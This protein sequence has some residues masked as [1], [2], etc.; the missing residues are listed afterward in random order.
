MQEG[1]ESLFSKDVLTF[2][3]MEKRGM[4]MA[5]KKV[6]GNKERAAELLGISRK[7]FYRKELEYKISK[8]DV[9]I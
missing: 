7:T 9:T 1:P 6:S 3:E 2:T 4:I 5:L 8:N